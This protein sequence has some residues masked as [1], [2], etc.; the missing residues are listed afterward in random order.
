MKKYAIAL[1]LSLLAAC[2]SS[3]KNSGPA[4]EM[5]ITATNLT[6]NTLYFRGPMT[7][8]L[9]MTINNPTAD[10]ITLRSLDLRTEGPSAFR[11][12]TGSTAVNKTI[13]PNSS[14]TL[15]MSAWGQSAGGYFAS[16]E[17]ISIRGLAYFDSPHGS[18]TR[19]FND[20]IT[21]GQ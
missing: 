2:A 6:T 3:N 10:A 17:P 5:H 16:S 9:E 19:L 8:A 7:A 1:S 4:V 13:P 15:T 11:L 20:V 12:R 14:A 18:F 21:P